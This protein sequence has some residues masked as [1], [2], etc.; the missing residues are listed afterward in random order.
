MANSIDI[1]LFEEA[2]WDGIV[3]LAY[4]NS[5]VRESG[6]WPLM[7]TL[8]QSGALE[9]NLFTYYTD[10]TLGAITFGGVNY[11]HSASREAIW[12]PLLEPKYWT[13]QL[14]SVRIDDY[15]LTNPSP[16]PIKAVIDTG[17][18]LIYGPAPVIEAIVALVD[19]HSCDIANLPVLTFV[20][21]GQT[22][23]V[24]VSLQPKDYVLSFE[25]DAGTECVTGLAADYS[26][27][28]WTLGQVFLS[29][30][31]S[32]F[33]RDNSRIGFL[34]TKSLMW[35]SRNQLLNK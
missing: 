18:F 20:F 5:K 28:D 31:V 23:L 35:W 25:T 4:P 21:Q 26:D 19:P 11:A 10:K 9:Q 1:P 33:D 12:V 8:M 2:K 29:A 27:S 6:I 34:R 32:I 14:I 24:E 13:L 7:D 17:T 16:R 22:E 3:G 15:T 30:Y